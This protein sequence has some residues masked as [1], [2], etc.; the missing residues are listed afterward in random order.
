MHGVRCGVN[1]AV[2][3][4]TAHKRHMRTHMG[5]KPFSCAECGASFSTS[6][7]LKQ[8]MVVHTG[9]KPFS[10]VECGAAFGRKGGFNRHMW[11]HAGE[12]PFSCAECGAT[13]CHSGSL[14][15]H[16]RTCTS[17]GREHRFVDRV[18][19]SN[20]LTQLSSCVCGAG[21]RRSH[22]M[23]AEGVCRNP[24]LLTRRMGAPGSV[25]ASEVRALAHCT[26]SP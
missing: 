24:L 11:T 10:C 16:T 25:V 15:L 5:E 23:A 21:C 6:G 26:R 19:V 20:A 2:A 9:E 4:Q 12:K 17:D 3:P 22:L 1:V 18:S 8:H 7:G 14:T 13:F